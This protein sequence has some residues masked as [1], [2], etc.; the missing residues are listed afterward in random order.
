MSGTAPYHTRVRAARA[1]ENLRD[2]PELLNAAAQSL[3][4]QDVGLPYGSRTAARA[5][6]YLDPDT[7]RQYRRRA[8]AEAR[9]TVALAEAGP[10]WEHHA[11]L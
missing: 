10:P 9:R 7:R 5:W 11:T 1:V 6:R 3:F 4:C 8:L 2:Q